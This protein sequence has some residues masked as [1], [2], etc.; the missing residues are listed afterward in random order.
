MYVHMCVYIYIYTYVYS[1]I[2]IY[3]SIYTYVYVYVYIYVH[4]YIYIYIF[5]ASGKERP[6]AAT[7]NITVSHLPTR[8]ADPNYCVAA[9]NVDEDVSGLTEESLCQTFASPQHAPPPTPRACK[10]C[11]VYVNIENDKHDH[12][13]ASSLVFQG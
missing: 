7:T 13:C 4:I 6:Q 11:G 10:Y 1:Y 5:A 12:L 2:Y 8:A 3:V 9:K